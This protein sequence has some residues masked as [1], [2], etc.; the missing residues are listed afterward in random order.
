MKQQ[1]YYNLLKVADTNTS[2]NRW[3]Q[4]G[5]WGIGAAL[6]PLLFGAKPWVSL[7]TGALGFAAPDIYDWWKKPKP[8]QNNNNNTVQPTPTA[9]IDKLHPKN[10]KG[11]EFVIETWKN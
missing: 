11:T 4:R 5:A 7:L 1:T 6:L 8:K 9:P 2:T 10:R 3:M